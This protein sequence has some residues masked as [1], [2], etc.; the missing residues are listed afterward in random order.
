MGMLIQGAA[1]PR[2]EGEEP[3]ETMP[4]SFINIPAHK[5]HCAEWTDPTVRYV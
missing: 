1:R 5:R 4:G 3:L 2:L